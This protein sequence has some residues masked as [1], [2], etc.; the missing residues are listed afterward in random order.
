MR[1]VFFIIFLFL[2]LFFVNSNGQNTFIY[3]NALGAENLKVKLITSADYI[4]DLPKKLD[5]TIIDSSGNFKLKTSIN[6][7][8]YVYFK[9]GFYKG[10][11][12]LEPGKTYKISI[13]PV[14]Y[15]VD[16]NESPFLANN[17]LDIE[18]L[19][20]DTA[21][22]NFKI[23]KFNILYNNFL[24]KNFNAI[25]QRRNKSKIDSILTIA[26]EI[27]GKSNNTFLKNYIKYRFASLEQAGRL[28]SNKLL[29]INYIM[30]QPVMYNNVEYMY[31]FNEFYKKFFFNGNH[32]LK[33]DDIKRFINV[34]RNYFTLLDSLGRD[35]L[36][37]NEVIRELV[38]LN[39]MKELYY[40]KI[41][42]NDNIIDIL[43]KF[44]TRSKFSEHRKIALNLI[45]TF[46]QLK[47]G[48]KAPDFKLLDL[49]GNSFNLNSFAGK[50]TYICFFTTWC[51]GCMYE[52]EAIDVIKKKYGDK[53]N[54][55]FISA[56]K[57]P[58]NLRYYLEKN[59]Y[60]WCFLNA[61]NNSDMLDNYDV[62][63]FPVF[64]LIDPQSKIVSYP[65]PKPSEG[66][67]SFFKQLF[68]KDEIESNDKQ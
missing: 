37:K 9:I 5:E 64:L 25:Y 36:V 56:D 2:F 1:K 38:F 35:S 22:L 47:V 32:S 7:V 43:N 11:F 17:L 34:E 44:A 67:E 62:K 55:V 59:K 65:A 14:N 52:N 61:G 12:Y 29:F 50:Y 53:V 68:S 45:E 20:N 28:K 26:N 63:S 46:I 49:N 57:Q 54:F 18:I 66:I 42:N 21:S 48:S 4:S 16:G 51:A 6:E 60:D 19:N 33:S 30:N 41:Y 31:F 8:L 40:S 27:V 13:Q 10:E 24:I 15:K 39:G 3:G 58:L 23:N